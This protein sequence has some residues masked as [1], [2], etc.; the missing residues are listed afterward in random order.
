MGSL[1]CAAGYSSAIRGRDRVATGPSVQRIK[2]EKRGRGVE[3]ARGV[4]RR[5]FLT[6][7]GTGSA[8][9]AA[10]SSGILV[11][12]A[13]GEEGQ[14]GGSQEEGGPSNSSGSSSGQQASVSFSSIQ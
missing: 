4:S 8:A 10:G 5:R 1:T 6:F 12:C 2:K 11:G 9:L 3:P 7:L 14:Q 13:E